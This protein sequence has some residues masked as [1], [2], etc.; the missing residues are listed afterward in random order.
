MDEKYLEMA[1]DSERSAIDAGIARVR[2]VV[3]VRPKDFDGTCECG[4]IIPQPRVTLGH[5]KCVECQ[6]ALERRGRHFV[7]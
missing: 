4:E 3:E 1:G 6:S 2:S 5:F 7:K